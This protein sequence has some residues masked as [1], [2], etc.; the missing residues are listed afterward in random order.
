M[1]VFVFIY[2]SIVVSLS[3]ILYLIIGG[4]IGQLLKI[5]DQRLEE[6]SCKCEKSIMVVFFFSVQGQWFVIEEIV[7]CGCDVQCC[8]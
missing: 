4:L 7:L 6:E 2:I 8:L 1:C 3:L 5:L